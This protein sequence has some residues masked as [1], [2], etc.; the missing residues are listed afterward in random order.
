MKLV[1]KISVLNILST[2]LLKSESGVYVKTLLIIKLNKKNCCYKSKHN[3]L[4]F[5]VVLLQT[6]LQSKH[7]KRKKH[8]KL[9]II[10]LKT[11]ILGSLKTPVN[12]SLIYSL[13]IWFHSYFGLEI[14]VTNLRGKG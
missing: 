11:G 12:Y 3:Q 5:C 4:H 13:N 2:E 8:Q 10:F 6:S 14:P 9:E 7:T 1:K